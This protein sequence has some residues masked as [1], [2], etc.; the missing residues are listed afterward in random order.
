MAVHQ[1]IQVIFGLL[2][3]T[4]QNNEV[5]I[6]TPMMRVTLPSRIQKNGQMPGEPAGISAMADVF[7]RIGAWVSKGKS[8][9]LMIQNKG[10]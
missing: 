1:Q 7:C 5:K 9:R 8:V 6:Q 2:F 10:R 4:R 3:L